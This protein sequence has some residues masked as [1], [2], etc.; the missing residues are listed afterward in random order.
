MIY[1]LFPSIASN[2]FASISDAQRFLTPANHAAKYGNLSGSIDF[3]WTYSTP[4][5]PRT[6]VHCEVRLTNVLYKRAGGSAAIQGRF[7]GR[8]TAIDD[9]ARSPYRIGFRLNNLAFSDA[10]SYHCSMS[11]DGGPLIRSREYRFRIYGTYSVLIT[12]F[13]PQSVS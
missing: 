9:T 10:S 2:S 5:V 13:L 12:K 6:A 7:V 3:V 11:Y 4:G 1:Q 8:A